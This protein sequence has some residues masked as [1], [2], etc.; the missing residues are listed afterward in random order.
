MLAPPFTTTTTIHC[1]M[2]KL[3]K[4][5]SKIA[6]LCTLCIL[7]LVIALGVCSTFERLDKKFAIEEQRSDV[8]AEASFVRVKL[9][10]ELN[11]NLYLVS[12]LVHFISSHPDLSQDEFNR[13]AGGMLGDKSGLKSISAA[14]DLIVKYL[15]PLKGNESVLGLNYRNVKAQLGEVLRAEEKGSPVLAGPVN[16]VQGG[17]AFIARF[18]VFVESATGRKYWG[19]VSTLLDIKAT[20]QKGGLLDPSLRINIR[21][22][23]QNVETG[24]VELIY[25]NDDEVFA[26]AAFLPVT[27][28]SDRWQLEA[29]PKGGWVDSAPNA[30]TIRLLTFSVASL[31][32][33]IIIQIYFYIQRVE[34]ARVREMEANLSKTHFLANMSH[35]LRTPLNGVLGAAQLLQTMEL[36]DEQA[37]WTDV[38]IHSGNSLT[39]LIGDIL[40][41]SAMEFGRLKI[42]KKVFELK[43]FIEDLFCSIQLNA[44]EKGIALQWNPLPLDCEKIETDQAR[45]RQVLWALL[46][47]A[48]KFTKEGSVTLTTEK[49]SFSKDT[50]NECIQFSVVDTGVGIA[51]ERL[52]VI[53]KTFEQED[54]SSTREFSGSGLGLAIAWKLAR[55]LDGTLEVRSKIGHGSS[56]IVCIPLGKKIPN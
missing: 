6:Y 32:I 25:P 39:N 41:L 11:S 34:K 22:S 27:V 46:T 23:K 9:E 14:P 28:L 33:I 17:Q 51:D 5:D 19:I 49:C 12:G 7:I 1:I 37:Y 42:K 3:Y 31:L 10:A 4:L 43:P 26:N 52:S 47:N 35:E 44:E 50:E 56:F 15:Y 20:Y 13:I 48:V 2:P 45:L 8:L 38:I 53:F 29:S 24:D 40:D 55:E 36:K 16:L 30:L 54:N 18:P 21:L